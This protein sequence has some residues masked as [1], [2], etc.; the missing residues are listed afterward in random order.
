MYIYK[1]THIYD[2]SYNRKIVRNYFSKM[3]FLDMGA[4]ISF[5]LVNNISCNLSTIKFSLLWDRII[6]VANSSQYSLSI[7][8]T[9][10]F[11]SR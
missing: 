6:Y 10:Q 3:A 7:I 9:V 8:L 4:L 2:K 5:N 1:E 11:H